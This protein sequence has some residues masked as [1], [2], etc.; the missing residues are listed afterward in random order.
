MDF[1]SNNVTL[2]ILKHLYDEECFDEK[3][4][5]IPSSEIIKKYRSIVNILVEKW[6][7]TEKKYTWHSSSFWLSEKWIGVVEYFTQRLMDII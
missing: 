1:K 3:N 4:W 6:F 2:S 5:I 7:I